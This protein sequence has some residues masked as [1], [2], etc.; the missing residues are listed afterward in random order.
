MPYAIAHPV[1][2]IPLARVLGRFAVPSALAIGS[3]IPDAWYLVPG[4]DRPLSHAAPGLF[5]FCLPA[6]LLAYVAFHLLFKEPLLH[7]L[8]PGIAVRARSFACNGLP[9]AA[10]LAVLANLLLGAATHQAWD[11]FTHAG[12]F[13]SRFLDPAVARVLQHAS[14]LLGGAFLAWW[15]WRK[16]KDAPKSTASVLP[17]RPRKLVVGGLAAFA[18]IAFTAMLLLALPELELRQSLR[19]AAVAGACALGLALFLFALVF[20]FRRG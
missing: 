19:V 3:V 4:L 14:T 9:R 10:W 17:S 2:A 16:L 13:A 8:P 1:A 11:A 7:L 20:R 15:T 18:G 5:L 6:G 12:P